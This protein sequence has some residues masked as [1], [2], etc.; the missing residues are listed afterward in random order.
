MEFCPSS[1]FV[2]VMVYQQ[3][4]EIYSALLSLCGSPLLANL[5]NA[6]DML[7]LLGRR[8]EQI[9]QYTVLKKSW[10]YLQL[11]NSSSAQFF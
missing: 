3:R 11:Q 9:L 1:F 7:D 2:V 5:L 8:E 6:S 4:S 10:R